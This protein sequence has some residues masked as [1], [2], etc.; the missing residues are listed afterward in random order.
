MDMGLNAIEH[1]VVLLLENR[2][3]DHMLGYLSLEEGRTDVDGLK[4]GLKN[5]W[6]GRDYPV[7]H[8]TERTL[9]ADP[10][11]EGPSCVDVQI[12]NNCSGF[13]ENFAAVYPADPGLIMGY[14]NKDDVPVFHQLAQQFTICDRWFSSVAGPTIP[15]RMYAVAGRS[16]GMRTSPPTFPPPIYDMAT[17][18]DYLNAGVPP[19]SWR[20]FAGDRVFSMLRLFRNYRTAGESQIANMDAF[21]TI[22][23]AGQLP[24]VTW[25]EPDYGILSSSENDDHP[26]TD[27]WRAQKLVGTIYNILLKA[28]HDAWTRTLFILTYDEHGG[29]YDHVSPANQAIVPLPNDDPADGKLTYGV[30]VPAFIISP[31]AKRRAV[32]HDVFDHTSILKTILT[33]FLR[34]PDGSIPPMHARVDAARSLGGLLSEPSARTDAEPVTLPTIATPPATLP[35]DGARA[36]MGQG[37]AAAPAMPQQAVKLNEFQATLK[38]VADDARAR[39]PML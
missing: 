38:S 10:C 18:F 13:V 17:I 3:F 23:A 27:I 19:V 34:H 11:H 25:L 2:S 7:R 35:V 6:K 32:A 24:S 21:F 28:A 16:Q 9:P 20:A 15:N 4:P 14:Y 1:I 36:L 31:W 30:R 37:A 12:A 8:L 22:A 29:I 26:P 5:S 33:R 39:S